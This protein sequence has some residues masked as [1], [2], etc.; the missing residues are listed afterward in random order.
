MDMGR[1]GI[2]PEDKKLFNQW[3]SSL[4]DLPGKDKNF[5]LR[6]V[7]AASEYGRLI[8]YR[9]KMVGVSRQR[10]RLQGTPGIEFHQ[11]VRLIYPLSRLEAIQKHRQMWYL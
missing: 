1:R 6:E 5:W 3:C 2:I 9:E 8:R 7:P 10:Q 4:W 11:V